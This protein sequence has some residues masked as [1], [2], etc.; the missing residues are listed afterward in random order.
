MV[1]VMQRKT[2]EGAVNDLAGSLWVGARDTAA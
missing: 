2:E 1:Y